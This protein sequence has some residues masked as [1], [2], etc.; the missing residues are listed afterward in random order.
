MAS[1]PSQRFRWMLPLVIAA[2]VGGLIGAHNGRAVASY[3]LHN[4]GRGWK[5]LSRTTGAMRRMGRVR[6]IGR[7]VGCW[8]MAYDR[9]PAMI[10]R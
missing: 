10:F 7:Q 9:A 3:G 5:G 1:K 2:E 4:L 6:S 8:P